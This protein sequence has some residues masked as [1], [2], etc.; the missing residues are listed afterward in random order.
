MANRTNHTSSD[1]SITP[2]Q[3]DESDRT[4]HTDTT[5]EQLLA[6]LGELTEKLEPAPAPK[7][8][9]V[10]SWQV[11]CLAPFY[12]LRESMQKKME[13]IF[14]DAKE[15]EREIKKAVRACPPCESGAAWEA[16]FKRSIGQLHE[17]V[18]V[19][20]WHTASIEQQAFHLCQL[21]VMAAGGDPEAVASPQGGE[22]HE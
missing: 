13:A 10:K 22:C 9:K 16:I 3:S 20:G 17:M 12:D 7:P 8:E 14:A 4:R 2:T 18:T 21:A 5:R 15:L 6:L 19:L 11:E 1:Q